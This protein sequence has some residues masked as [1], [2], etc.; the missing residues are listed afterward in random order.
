[1]S[2]SEAHWVLHSYSLVPYQR[3]KFRNLLKEMD[4]QYVSRLH[5]IIIQLQF[6]LEITL[7]SIFPYFFW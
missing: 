2:E 7:F 3:K 4:V 1:M 5:E 6:G